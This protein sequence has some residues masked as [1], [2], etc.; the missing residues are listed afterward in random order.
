MAKMMT[1]EEYS[2]MTEKLMREHEAAN[3]GKPVMSMEEFK[4]RFVGGKRVP[5]TPVTPVKKSTKSKKK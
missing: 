5:G 4:R 2:R 3:R 1:T